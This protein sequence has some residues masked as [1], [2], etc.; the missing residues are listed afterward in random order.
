LDETIG[1]KTNQGATY[2]TADM[3]GVHFF[4]C[5]LLWRLGQG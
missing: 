3:D 4:R 1:P 2:E 5:D